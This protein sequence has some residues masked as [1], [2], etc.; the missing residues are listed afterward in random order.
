MNLKNPRVVFAACGAAAALAVAGCGD[1]ANGNDVLEDTGDTLGDMGDTAT[2]D[3]EDFFGQ[4]GDTTCGEFAE[5]DPETQRTTV[6]DYLEQEG[7]QDPS[8]AEIDSALLSIDAMCA[9]EGDEET[10]ISE[11]GVTGGD[12]GMPEE[13]GNGGTGS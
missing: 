1:D 8:E 2:E 7:Q 5:Q 6:T 9:L 13:E 3:V 12:T 11:A 10:P 4:G